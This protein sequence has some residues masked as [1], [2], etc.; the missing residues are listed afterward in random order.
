MAV[1]QQQRGGM[2]HRFTIFVF[3]FAVLVGALV[4]RLYFLQVVQGE[5][6]EALASGNRIREVA[7]EAQRGY[8]LDRNGVKMVVNR[9]ALSIAVVPDDY[10]KVEDREEKVA[11]L[12]AILD[13]EPESITGKLR[14]GDVPQHEPVLIKKDIDP[15]VWFYL[16]ERKQDFPWVQMQEL[17]VRDYP[18]GEETRAAHVLGYLGEISRE[19]LEALAEKGYKAGDIVGTSGVEAYYE[20]TLRG[21]NGVS[22]VE[23]DARGKPLREMGGESPVPGNSLMLTLDRGL[24]EVAEESLLAGMQMAR[25][26]YDKEREQNFPATAGAVVVL[27]PRNGE[28]LAMASEPAFD[29]SD[30]V[31]GINEQKW[32]EMN[33]PS[34]HYPLNNRAMVGQYPPGSTFKPITAMA[35]MEELGY[36]PYTP[37]YCGHVFDVG[38]FA[39][40]YR[41]TCWGEHGKIDLVNGIVQSCDV[42]FY[43]IGYELYRQSKPASNPAGPGA[44]WRNILQDY[45][46]LSGLGSKTG[47]DLPN[48]FEGR[49]PTPAWKRDFNRNNPEYQQWNPGDTVSMAIG[50]GDILV[51]PLQLANIF[52][53]IAN[54]GVFYTPHVGKEVLTWEGDSKEVIQPEKLGD[55]TDT[56][57]PLGIS[58]GPESIETVRAGLAGVMQGKGTAAATFAGFPLSVIPVAGKTGTAEMGEGRSPTAWFACYA[59]ADD[60]QYVIVVMV[61]HGGHGGMVAAPVARRILEHIYQ[62]PYS[63]LLPTPGD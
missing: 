60:P 37:F 47:I 58:V 10:K 33:D 4:I 40:I 24:Q 61:E 44:E 23:V 52:A 12:A 36:S 9:L 34:K 14:A 28:V 15:E 5:R 32:E 26:F 57:N 13:M 39:G 62:L 45:A 31:G 29:L 48:E 22:Y 6:Y 18:E 3:F 35:G 50:Q 63:P 8:V 20:D 25:G 41:K 2:V 27:D 30:F 16:I 21:V 1:N 55:L 49:V 17:P 7:L 46:R 59:P 43:T 54:R 11:E 38:E 19:Q 56:N 42:V 53:A 51:T